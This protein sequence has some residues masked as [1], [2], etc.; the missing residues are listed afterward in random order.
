ME[1]DMQNFL[2]ACLTRYRELTGI[3]YMRHATTPF[4]PEKMAPDFSDG[5]ATERIEVE[6]AEIALRNVAHLQPYAAKVLTKVF[7][8]ARYACLDLLSA[9]CLVAQHIATWDQFCDRRLYPLMC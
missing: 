5:Y 1:Y 6:A 2:V 3:Q 4:L 9:V 7:Y 8:I